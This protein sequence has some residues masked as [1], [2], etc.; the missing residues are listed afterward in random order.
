MDHHLAPHAFG[1]KHLLPE[2]VPLS[3]AAE[4]DGWTCSKEQKLADR[5]Q[6]WPCRNSRASGVI[7]SA[8]FQYPPTGL[9]A[10]INVSLPSNCEG[11]IKGTW[12]IS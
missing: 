12:E 3:V 2:M 1:L 7:A 10:H 8:H 6:R 11:D 5:L 9:L 4:V